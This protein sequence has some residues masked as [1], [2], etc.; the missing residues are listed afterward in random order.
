VSH[1][2]RI[3]PAIPLHTAGVIR[4]FKQQAPVVAGRTYGSS[5]TTR[6]GAR[7]GGVCRALVTAG[8][9]VV[10]DEDARLLHVM[11]PGQ[12]ALLVLAV[13]SRGLCG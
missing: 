5:I 4:P 9:A 8:L 10:T 3:V 13:G 12:S 11:A 2:G 7:C 1:F 6:I